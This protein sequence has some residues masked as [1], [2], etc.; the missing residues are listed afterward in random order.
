MC[1]CV[2]AKRAARDASRGFDVLDAVDQ[3]QAFV[4]RGGDMMTFEPT[5]KH[6]QVSCGSARKS[7]LV[8]N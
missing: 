3:L 8:Y 1:V 4:F 6:G 5:G 2:Q 7:S